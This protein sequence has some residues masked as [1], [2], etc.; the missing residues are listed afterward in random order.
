MMEDSIWKALEY[1]EYI[2]VTY[3]GCKIVGCKDQDKWVM[4]ISGRRVLL[5]EIEDIVNEFLKPGIKMALVLPIIQN[6]YFL[7]EV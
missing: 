5:E 1:D 6:Y 3:R 7:K 4:S 2:S